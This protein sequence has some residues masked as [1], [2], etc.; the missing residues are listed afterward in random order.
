M[1]SDFFQN[2]SHPDPPPA[3]TRLRHLWWPLVVLVVCGL[4]AL[5]LMRTGP[6]ARPR[7]ARPA[8][9]L[10]EVAPVR[11]RAQDTTIEAMGTVVAARQIDLK[12]QVGGRIIARSSELVPGGRFARGTELLRIDPADYRLAVR[13]LK[14]AVAQARAD[15]QQEQGRQLVARREY[16]LLGAPVSEAEQALMLRRPQLAALQAEL[17]KA[18]AQLAQGEL[19]LRR[20]VLRA[21]FNA[22]IRERQVDIG[23]LVGQTTVL[24]GLVGTDRYWVRVVVPVDELPWIRIP[25]RDGEQGS[26]VRIHDRAA[27]GEGVFRR[28]RVLRLEAGLE[29][30]GRMARLLVGVDDPLGLRP[31]ASAPPR[32]LLDS[33][34]R[35]T[36]EGKR[37]DRVAVLDRRHLHDGDRVWVMDNEDRLAIRPVV[38][39]FRNRNQVLVSAGLDPGARLVISDLAA[40]V[41]GMRLRLASAPAAPAGAGRGSSRR[42]GS[43]RGEQP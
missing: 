33:Y 22:M 8:A 28:G 29:E 21:P 41:Q 6:Q 10:V 14:S 40:P 27:W 30:Q 34:V 24:A 20:T 38:I 32:L 39:A 4:I 43:P 26:S 25:G 2:G 19:D 1:S 7:P 31:G 37:L 17:E 18:R 3:P 23:A 13:R 5:W 11:Y 16:Q 36:I 42:S 15:L 9:A 12:P 35:V